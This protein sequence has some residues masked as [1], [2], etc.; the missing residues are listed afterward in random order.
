MKQI[1]IVAPTASGK[2]ALSIELAHKTNSI[3]LSLDSLSVYKEIDIA[4]AKPTLDER[5]G[6]VHFGI[7]EIYP[8]EKFDVMEF[9]D[10]YERAKKYA[11]ENNKN[12]IIVGGTG[13]YLK[14]M[15]D[16]IS[17]LPDASSETMKWVE[18]HLKDTNEAHN[19]MANLDSVYMKNIESNDKYRIEKALTIYKQTGQ[20]PT[21]YFKEHPP[22][23]IIE[24]IE[25][26]EIDW[27]VKSLRERIAKRTKIMINSGLIDEVIYLEKK[28]TRSPNCMN[29]IG[30]NETLEYIDGKIS[31][32]DL[33][34]EIIINT[35][36][37]A[38]RQRTFNNGQFKKIIKDNISNLRC[39]ALIALK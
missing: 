30:I 2:T 7:D 19:Y 20:I 21:T 15:I 39:K 3:I 14:S 25:L 12:L 4:S 9:I 31:K 26:F 1:A 10:C 18:E 5:D 32:N 16:G 36:R 38:K 37:L 24:N 35:S 6:I 17:Y 28:Y 13:F 34:E 29:S 11:L 27:S 33:E 8:N 22:K 23:P